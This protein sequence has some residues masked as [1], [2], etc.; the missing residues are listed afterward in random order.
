MGWV[1]QV[2]A[3]VSVSKD[4]LSGQRFG[5]RNVAQSL[6]SN[7]IAIPIAFVIAIAVSLLLLLLLLHATA[8]YCF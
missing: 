1:G 3:S 5:G 6:E 2:Q 4:R 8:C 7:A